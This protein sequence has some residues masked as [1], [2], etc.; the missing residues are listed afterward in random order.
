MGVVTGRG[1]VLDPADCNRLLPR[2]RTLLARIRRREALRH[3]LESEMVVLQV[4][5]DMTRGSNAE[6]LEFVDKNVR[7]HRLGG[8]IDAL[9]EHLAS[10]G[11]VVKNRDAQWVD[12]V[13]LRDDG[14]AHMCWHQGEDL[15]EHWHHMH[16]P[17]DARRHLDASRS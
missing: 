13:F 6:F 16:E 5:G 12:F 11:C 2:V 17:H 10:L 15:V 7:F 14:L 4:L 3:R 1:R 8:Q 9:V